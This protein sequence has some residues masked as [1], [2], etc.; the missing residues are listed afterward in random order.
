MVYVSAAHPLPQAAKAED[1]PTT[2]TVTLPLAA[3]A[4][5]ATSSPT[6]TATPAASH[7]GYIPDTTIPAQPGGH[8]FSLIARIVLSIELLL[9]F[10]SEIGFPKQIFQKHIAMLGPDYGTFWLGLFQIA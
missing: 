6:T 8:V 3:F 9:L 10:L 1:A 7:G 4:V 5:T 2:T